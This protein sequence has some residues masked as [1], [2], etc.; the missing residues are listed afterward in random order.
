MD[1]RTLRVLRLFRIFRIL[2]AFRILRSAK[3]L[4]RILSTLVKSLPALRNLMLLLFLLFFV[5]AV[6][7]VV[8][9]GSVCVAGEEAA[10]GLT[11]VRCMFSEQNP[12]LDPRA[13]FRDLGHSLLSLFRVATTDGWS[14]LMF[15]VLVS[16]GRRAF[17][18]HF[19]RGS[20]KSTAQCLC[21][22]PWPH[23]SLT[24]ICPSSGRP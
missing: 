6:L 8:L 1:P 15:T 21:L 5:F 11:A 23:P 19:G 9:F 12:P 24:I 10:S 22:M 16:H 14:S 20:Y 7:G 3:G 2:R 18:T 4:A 13:N 17:R